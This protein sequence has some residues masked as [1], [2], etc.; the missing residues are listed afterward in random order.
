MT[1]IPAIIFSDLDGTLL[2]HQHYGFNAARP[3]LERLNSFG[4]PLILATSKTLAEVRAINR[5]LGAPRPAMV[6]NGGALCF[7][8]EQARALALVADEQHDDYAIVLRSP[9]YAAIREFIVQQREQHGWQLTGFGDMSVDEVAAQ[10]GLD[11]V[12]AARARQRLCSEPFT[13]HDST[14]RLEQFREQAAAARLHI[15]RGGRFWHLM[16]PTSKG[17]ALQAMCELLYPGQRDAL[18]VIALGDSENDRDM[19]ESAD[20]AVVVR[21]H[22]GTHLDCQ[23]KRRTL[24]TQQPGP[25]GW[26]T[27]VLQL[28]DEL[29]LSA[30][31]T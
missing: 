16:G 30:D 26:N 25:A 29:G 23:G 11:Q 28:L 20:I 3:A 15:T 19:L 8:S 17:A 21:R 27:A 4:I 13:W 5:Q 18:S 10:T 24:R 2:D 7:P 31:A 12:G 1:S 22:D 6:E 14:Q 9:A